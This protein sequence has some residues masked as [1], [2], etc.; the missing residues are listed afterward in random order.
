MIKILSYIDLSSM[1]RFEVVCICYLASLPKLIEYYYDISKVCEVIYI[2]L[3]VR[4]NTIRYISCPECMRVDFY[5]L[6]CE[7]N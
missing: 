5:L 7:F 4:R 3:F 6:L 1:Y 2:C